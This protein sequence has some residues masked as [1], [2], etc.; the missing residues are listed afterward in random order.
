MRPCAGVGGANSM[1]TVDLGTFQRISLFGGIYSNYLSLLK[2]MEISRSRGVDAMIALGDFGAFGP[3]P[4]RT[5]EILRRA[6]FPRSRATTRNR[7]RRSRRTATVATRTRA[8]TR[9]P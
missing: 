8:T 1:T 6:E 5:V 9:S 4:D 7:S 3:H 2:A